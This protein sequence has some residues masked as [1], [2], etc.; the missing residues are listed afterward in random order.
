MAPPNAATEAERRPLLPS[1]QDSRP[2]ASDEGDVSPPPDGGKAWIQVL[3]G[4]LVLFNSWGYINSYALFE[5]YYTEN[6]GLSLSNVSWAGSIQIFCLFFLGTFSG[7]A[8]DAGY[9]WLLMVTGAI[10]QVVGVF[11]TSFATEFWQLLVA[12]G[13][14]CGV[15]DGLMFCPT[16]SLVAT[17]FS[18][19]KTLALCT[20]AAGTSIGGV[21]FPVIAQQLLPR[22]GFEW[23][24]R[25]MGFVVLVNNV[26]ILALI[27]PRLPSRTTGPIVEWAAFREAPF[28]LI[29]IGM[30]LCLWSLYVA[31]SYITTYATQIVGVSESTSLTI[32]F[33]LNALGTPGRILPGL[34]A[35]RYGVLNTMVPFIALTGVLYFCWIAVG[36]SAELF[37]FVVLF[38]FIDAAVQGL[39]LG[40]LSAASPKLNTAGTRFGM[41]LSCV[42]FAALTGGPLFGALVEAG[43]GSFLYAQI[44]G[45]CALLVGGAFIF[46]A[47]VAKVGWSMTEKC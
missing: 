23:T 16:I 12:Q 47:R 3:A 25:V 37:I 36:S 28:T 32:F 41:I 2:A 43:N 46:G 44:W 10:L 11:A 38:G 35:D 40:A 22:V 4:F 24:V 21:V 17:Y 5:S 15:G 6:L 13:I 30:F 14:V 39:V 31:F 42:S 34:M 19:N 8:A 29:T 27:R 26:I 1:L 45:G 18:K 9:F 20:M 33:I 7:R